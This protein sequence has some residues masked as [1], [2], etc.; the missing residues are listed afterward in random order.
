MSAAKLK[1]IAKEVGTKYYKS[2]AVNLYGTDPEK[3]LSMLLSQKR[4][5]TSLIKDIKSM[6]KKL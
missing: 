1:D 4:S 2:G 3:A 5:K 6:Q